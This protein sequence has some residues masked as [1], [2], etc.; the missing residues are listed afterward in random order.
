EGGLYLTDWVEGWNTTGKGR[1]YRLFEPTSVQE[2]IVSQTKSLLA[3]GMG[4]RSS[5][6]LGSLLDHADMRVRQEA[7]FELADRGPDSVQVFASILDA[8]EFSLAQLHAIWGLGQLLRHHGQGAQVLMKSLYS[9][10]DEVRAQAAKVLGESPQPA[11]FGRLA[12]MV[13]SDR[14]S[15]ARFFAAIA[16]GKDGRFEAVEPLIALL[17]SNDDQDPYLRHAAVM[18]L[19]GL[20]DFR[21]IEALA[22]HPSSAVRMGALLAMRRLERPEVSRFLQDDAPHLVT[23]AARAINDVP[24]ESAMTDL[25]AVE[26]SPDLD[27]PALRRVVNANFRLGREEYAIRLGALAK[28]AAMSDNLRAEALEA[29]AQWA[30]PSGRDRVTGIWQPLSS[31]RSAEDARRRLRREALKWQGE[32]T[33]RFAT[34]REVLQGDDLASQQA[35]LASL[36][37]ETSSEA[38]NLLGELVDQLVEGSLPSGLHL[39]VIEWVEDKGSASLKSKVGSFQETLKQTSPFKEFASV[40]VGGDPEAGRKIFLEREEVACL[41]CHKVGGEGGEVGPVLDG[42][43]A[44][45]STNYIL[46]SILYP[47]QVIAKGYESVLIETSDDEYYAGII[48]EEEGGKLILESPEDGLITLASDQIK[49]REKGLSGMPEGLYL[50]LSKRELRDLMAFLASLK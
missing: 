20:Q 8:E 48:K 11:A 46:E 25:A 23:E 17:Q 9:G 3:D 27:E 6:A 12:T 13:A 41:R 19:K 28:H 31:Y 37:R 29:L 45:Q 7:Q 14:S 2:K 44:R 5:E 4:S 22:D 10:H 39:D 35:A 30:A 42:L 18:G 32:S 49:S 36:R 15:R 34:I 50:M 38:L 21:W 33:D 43:A 40:L 26:I 47:N 16:L 24:I 1:L